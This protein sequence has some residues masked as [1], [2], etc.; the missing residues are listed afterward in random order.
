MCYAPSAIKSL[1]VGHASPVK[2]RATGGVTTPHSEFEA[3]LAR[4][5]QTIAITK[6]AS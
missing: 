1:H 5:T 6:L 4:F 3:S 2:G